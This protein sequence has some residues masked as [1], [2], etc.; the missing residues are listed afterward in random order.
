MSR[1]PAWVAQMRLCL[2][3]TKQEEENFSQSLVAHAC[4]PS[5]SGNRDHEDCGLRPAEANSS[6]DPISKI[7][8][9][10]KRRLTE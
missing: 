6:Q 10:H 8:N 2:K 1:R 7:L 5:Y 3:K 4:N 9:T